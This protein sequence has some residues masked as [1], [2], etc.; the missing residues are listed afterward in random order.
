MDLVFGYHPSKDFEIGSAPAFVWFGTSSSGTS[1]TSSFSNGW[2]SP[3]DVQ[4][5]RPSATATAVSTHH[6]LRHLDP[7]RAFQLGQD[8]AAGQQGPGSTPTGPFGMA[9]DYNGDGFADVM[10]ADGNSSKIGIGYDWSGT[11]GNIDQRGGVHLGTDIQNATGVDFDGDGQLDFFKTPGQ[12]LPHLLQHLRHR[13]ADD[14]DQPRRRPARAGCGGQRRGVLPGDGRWHL[15]LRGHHP[16]LH[17]RPS[18]RHR[19]L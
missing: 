14:G 5:V 6:R 10:Y 2:Q 12:H 17:H 19:H 7:F 4:A 11:S 13:L 9:G 8:A 3:E 1:F 15:L 18:Q 16:R